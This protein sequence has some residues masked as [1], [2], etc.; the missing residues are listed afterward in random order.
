MNPEDWMHRLS[1]ALSLKEHEQDWGIC[2]ADPDRVLE[3]IAFYRQH[4]PRH[5]WDQEALA[6][7]ILESSNEALLD[8][9]LEPACQRALQEFILMHRAEFPHQWAYWSGLDDSEFP[10]VRYLMD[11]E[12]S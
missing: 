2:N 4:I 10:V 5:Q 3:F 7:L 8:G 1:Q 12:A 6:E 11:A 9:P